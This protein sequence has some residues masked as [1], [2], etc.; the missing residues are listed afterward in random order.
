MLDI[1]PKKSSLS[2]KNFEFL[3]MQKASAMKIAAIK[4]ELR[5]YIP[6][7]MYVS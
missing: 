4:I 3:P 2:S 1:T 7:V 5:Q 6:S